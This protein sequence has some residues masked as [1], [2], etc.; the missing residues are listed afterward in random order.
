MEHD[1]FQRHMDRT[2][3]RIDYSICVADGMDITSLPLADFVH[4][5]TVVIEQPGQPGFHVGDLM[6]VDG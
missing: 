2:R 6:G 4:I 3:R 5:H 1:V